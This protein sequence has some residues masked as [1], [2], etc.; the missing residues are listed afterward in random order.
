MNRLEGVCLWRRRKTYAVPHPVG[1]GRETHTAR[2]DGEREDLAD[3]DPRHGT[4]GEGEDG[5]VDHD[6]GDHGRHGSVIVCCEFSGSNTDDTDD[7]LGGD[8]TDGAPDEEGS[9][10]P[11]VDGVERKRGAERV[12][13]SAEDGDQEGVVDRAEGG[14]E[15]GSEVEDEV[16]SGQLLHHLHEYA[17]HGSAN[18][19]AAVL[20]RS[21][22]AVGPAAEVSRAWDD[23]H[24]VLVVGNN[25][26]KLGLDELR[27]YRLPANGA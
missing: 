13:E 16:D 12:D 2:A 9:A 17:E 14:Q 5:D 3:D 6:E 25:L 26:S 20:E 10:A 23:G 18:V 27:F 1:S 15:D 21:L 19:A 4:P 8:H 7:E 11:S 24:F 22:E